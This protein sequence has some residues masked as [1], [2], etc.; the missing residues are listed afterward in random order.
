MVKAINLILIADELMIRAI[1]FII[2][3]TKGGLIDNV[4]CDG[5][6]RFVDCWFFGFKTRF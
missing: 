4:E 2:I 3:D 5:D 1:L 6:T